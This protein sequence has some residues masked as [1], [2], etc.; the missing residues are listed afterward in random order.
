[1]DKSFNYLFYYHFLHF[2]IPTRISPG[3][4]PTTS[5]FSFVVFLKKINPNKSIK[6]KS[7]VEKVS[8]V[9]DDKNRAKILDEIKNLLKKNIKMKI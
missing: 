2:F 5:C 7:F 4:T 6:K 3:G 1:M 9:I 8:K